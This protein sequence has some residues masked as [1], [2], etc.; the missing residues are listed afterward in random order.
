MRPAS[1]FSASGTPATSARPGL[2]SARENRLAQ[3]GHPA[4]PG[5]AALPAAEVEEGAVPRPVL[6]S[7]KHLSLRFYGER[8]SKEG[9]VLKQEEMGANQH[10][11]PFLCVAKTFCNFYYYFYYY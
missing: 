10:L 2:R 8:P 3:A 11:I 9:L 7:A 1:C 6:E 5:G 4:L